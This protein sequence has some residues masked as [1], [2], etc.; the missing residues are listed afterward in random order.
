VNCSPPRSY[1]ITNGLIS[2]SYPPIGVDGAESSKEKTEIIFSAENGDSWFYF[3]D[4][5]STASARKHGAKNVDSP[6]T[7]ETRS[8]TETTLIRFEHPKTP[9]HT[10]LHQ[11]KCNFAGLRPA[12]E[13][14]TLNDPDRADIG[15][16]VQE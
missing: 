4:I 16:R 11:G 2:I 15:L 5:S 6:V 10:V 8:A 14:G 1:T 13:A 9:E 7:I 3:E 12:S